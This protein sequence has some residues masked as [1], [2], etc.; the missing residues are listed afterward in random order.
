[1]IVY[2]GSYSTT[3]RK[4]YLVG[5]E[6][7]NPNT[8]NVIVEEVEKNKDEDDWLYQ[9]DTL[10]QIKKGEK[11]IKEGKKILSKYKTTIPNVEK[12]KRPVDLKRLYYEQFN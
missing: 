12:L 5:Y 3:C 7:G 6:E 11:E 8:G 1:M 4:E 10:K 2:Y 9:P